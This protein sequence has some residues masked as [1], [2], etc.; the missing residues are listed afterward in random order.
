MT[1]TLN[2]GF[3]FPLGG[4]GGDPDW[5]SVAAVALFDSTPFTFANPDNSAHALSGG[6][7]D[8]QTTTTMFSSAGSLETD[9]GDTGSGVYDANQ[10]AKTYFGTGPWT[11]EGW[12]YCTTFSPPAGRGQAFLTNMQYQGGGTPIGWY[13]GF[14]SSGAYLQLAQSSSSWQAWTFGSTSIN[15]WHYIA[16]ASSGTASGTATL[17]GYVTTLGNSTASRNLNS[18]YT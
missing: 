13:V 7:T 18:T 15:T 5:S 16:I 11:I 17:S 10:L 1:L 3:W 2:K 12:V 14:T 9:Q 6:N 8:Q 4:G